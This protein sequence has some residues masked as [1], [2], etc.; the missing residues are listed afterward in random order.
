GGGLS[1]AQQRFWFLQQ[2][3]SESAVYNEPMAFKLIGTLDTAALKQAI[4]EIVRRHEVLRG[5]Y[6][7]V[8]GQVIQ[9]VS[10]ILHESFTI[11]QIDLRDV[12]AAEREAALQ[13][14]MTQQAQ[15]P[16]DLER[17]VPWRIILLKLDDEEHVVLA[18][19]HHII[20]DAWSMEVFARELATLY[21]A[22][23]AQ[24]PSPLPELPL[25]YTD[26][27]RWQ[28][29]RL[30]EGELAGELA[31]WKR[32]LGGTLPVLELPSDRPRSALLTHRGQK[33][34]LLLPSSLG[35][36]LRILSRQEEVTLFMTLLAVFKVLLFRYTGQ[37][38]ILVGSP[39]ANRGYPA[40]ENLL[41]CFVNTL[42]LRTDMAGNPTFR[43]LLQRVRAITMDAYE[44]QD[45]PFEKLV[46][47]LL[48]TRDLSHSALFQVLF[49]MQNVPLAQQELPG[50][51]ISPIDVECGT[52]KFDVLLR[53]Q[54]T[55][56]ALHGYLE[57][58]TDLF[59]ASTIERMMGH[60]RQLLEAV[61]TDP[62]QHIAALPFLTEAQQQQMAAWNATQR[63]YPQHC[64]L[65]ELVEA[66]VERTPAAI[67]VC[68]EQEQLTY[69][70]LNERANALARYL[71]TLGVGPEILVGVCMERSIEL[72]VSLLAI[73]KAGGA[74]VPLDPSYP[75][76]RLAFL[77]QDAQ[78]ALLLIQE[79]LH[80][81]LPRHITQVVAVDSE[82]ARIGQESTSNPVNRV[83]PEHLAY[84]IYTSGSTG[85]PKG[86]MNS[87]RAICNRLLWMQDAYQLQATDRVLQKTPFSFDVSVWEFF[88]PLLTGARL[89]VAR[90]NG[91]R[92]GAYLVQL[93]REAQ[94]TVL[95]F[96]PSMLR[97]FLEEPEVATC[98]GLRLVICSGE[99]LAYEVQQRF[100]EH[101]PGAELHNLYG[102]TEAAVDVTSWA[103]EPESQRR[104]V[105]IGSPIAN[106]RIYVLDTHLNAMPIGI[107]G[108]LHIGGVGV[109]RGY[110]NRPELTAEKFIPDPFSEEP[111]ARLYKTGDL[112]RYLPGGILE[113]V[114]RNDHQVKLRGFRIELGEIEAELAGYPGVR[115]CAVLV[116]EDVPDDKRLVAY[117][118][119]QQNWPLS[120]EE[121]QRFIKGVLPDYMVPSAFMFLE[122]LPLSANGKLDRRALPVPGSARSIQEVPFEAPHDLIEEMVAD[123]WSDILGVELIGIHNDFFALGGHSLL[124]TQV[125]SRIRN[126]FEVELQLLTLF[127]S[128]TVAGLVRHIKAFQQSE[129]GLA[130]PPMVPASRAGILPL[131]FT[132]QRLWF[133]D[134]LEPANPVYNISGAVRLSGPLQSQVVER[135]IN[136]VVR[137]HEIL[138]TT[139][140]MVD[141]Q[142]LQVI[143][144]SLTLPL[145]TVD[146]QGLHETKRDVEVLRLISEEMR[147]PFDLARGP[148][149]RSTL[150]KLTA[151]EHILMLSVHHIVSDGWSTSVFVRELTALY[152][153]FVKDEMPSPLPELPV[154]YVDYAL[155]QQKWLQGEVLETQLAFWKQ[156]LAGLPVLQLPTDKPR[157]AVQTFHGANQQIVLTEPLTRALKALSR[158]EGVTLFMTLLATY[159]T[160][161]F[162]YTDQND[163]AVGIPIAGRTE[164]SLEALIG[165]FIN[166]LALRSDLSG[167]PTFRELLKRVRSVA[168]GA[169]AHQD[170]PFEKLVEELQ[171]D[172]DL[173]RSPLFQVM[174]ALQNVPREQVDL[175]E[176]TLTHLRV[177]SEPALFDLDMTLWESDDE[178]VGVLNYNTDLFSASTIQR[179]R[180]N[181]QRLLETVVEDPGQHLLDLPLLTEA[182]QE[183]IVVE[184]NATSVAYARE[185]TFVTLF[186][187][188][189]ERTP[190]AVA[191]RYARAHITYRQLNQRA[192]QVA[193]HLHDCSIGPE[194]LVALLAERD[195]PFLTAILAVFKAGGAYLPL[196]PQHP[197]ARLRHVLQHSGCH[198][199]LTA[200][201]FASALSE[202]LEEIPAETRPQV[203]LLEELLQQPHIQHNLAPQPSPRQLAY[204][205]YTSG[206]TGRPKGAMVEQ[207][208]MLNHLYAKIADLQLTEADRVAQT[209]S[210]CFDISVWQ[211][212]AALVVGG[213]VQIFP[214]EVTPDPGRL[215]AQVEE[216]HISILEIVPSMMRAM[217][218]VLELSLTKELKLAALRWLIPTGEALPS[219]LCRH[220]LRLY[221]AIPL[222][223]AYGPTECSDDVTHHPISQLLDETSCMMP[224]GRAIGN[225]RLYVLDRGMRP[226][227]IGVSG[228]LYIG[229]IGVG[230]GYV[231]DATRTAEA[232]VPDPF[233]REFG[234][235]L[236]NTGDVVRYLN[237]CTLEFLGRRDHQVKIRGYRI[238][239]GEIEAV[240]A[241]H[242]EVRQCAVLARE[243]VPG[244]SRLVAY[245][246]P[247]QEHLLGI[248]LKSSLK[249]LLP[250]YMVPSAFVFIKTLPLTPNGKLNRHALPAPD[251]TSTESGMPFVAPRNSVEEVLTGIWA[252]LLG[253]AREHISIHEDF[254]AIGGH[255]LLTVRLVSEIEKHFEVRLPLIAIFQGRTVEALAEVLRLQTASSVVELQEPALDLQAE[256]VL[257]LDI[258]P[259]VRS[260]ELITRP[261][262]LLLTG[263]TGFLG[264]FLLGELLQHTAAQI[265]CLLRASS[266]E[267]AQQRLQHTLEDA[268]LWQPA[269]RCRIVA[270]KGDLAEPLLGLSQEQFE[271]LAETLEVIYHNGA[272]VNTLYPY[273]E[274]KA[275]NV[276][277][278]QEILRLA[279]H[280]K[281]KPLHYIS[282]LSVFS[283]TATLQELPILED[284]GSDLPDDQR[285]NSTGQRAWLD[286]R[287]TVGTDAGGLRK[288]SDCGACTT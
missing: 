90:P 71:Q 54:E 246:V 178:I 173:S 227:P 87:H 89:V 92:D 107:P 110:Y 126:T 76:E 236:Y 84:L 140:A 267:E 264:C 165:C 192:N 217:L 37:E 46:E 48:P 25:Q 172:R 56:D 207:Q 1:F 23:S 83:K 105:P 67:A 250:D 232:F 278:T 116:R 141:G 191:A 4:Q 193:H 15:Y 229:G 78:V 223:N 7:M 184:W 43:Q 256:A 44:H 95:H 114:G 213:Q 77:L 119:A 100:F 198:L 147:L 241:Q 118:V 101:L 130:M 269:Y 175:P 91:H 177:D 266:T 155:W 34:E 120:Q 33:R 180:N 109:G 234:A 222:L 127:E 245:V 60:F 261:S 133:F 122:E 136:E 226:V 28:R 272:L 231:A 199:V 284:G 156:Q 74:Y 98:N 97:S 196:D 69:R 263:A 271:E 153:A 53:L 166:T 237:D 240:L 253:R 224:I 32:Q 215:L 117:V 262:H 251:A 111:G 149:L 254:F 125:I 66:Q 260:G 9:I 58:N 181:F 220:W 104:I 36:A 145:T 129:H 274:L 228:E 187:A 194:R 270:V 80:T 286:C 24:Q 137:R 85:K 283:H 55:A 40:Y 211:F 11:K 210:Q 65:H 169:Y 14:N 182:E 152:A 204:V 209:A 79:R 82:W 29:Q 244:D 171:S 146:L 2:L 203:L 38:D 159:Q 113:Y 190:D 249:E 276:L 138:R 8:N 252:A 144:P 212:L 75:Q 88:W 135:C 183:Q 195:I 279:T 31:Y 94:I 259:E 221:P 201:V 39:T 160:L 265:Y 131:S 148:L 10:P 188:Q 51:T 63:A 12:P 277:G 248:E 35:R 186:E 258:C 68:F 225:I 164:S 197:T 26:Y 62:D 128:P 243:D 174:F 189:V 161:L 103:C 287:G 176:L 124:A 52:A 150:L 158:R 200:S 285:I 179:I 49:V 108:E 238:E 202:A 21:A 50:F 16:F 163:F 281:V 17:E 30:E 218:E 139:F 64:T 185:Q 72:V 115:E 3:E 216:Q 96:V 57:Y 18:V 275:P 239:L 59:E 219:D 214:D 268:G 27:A 41:G 151:E 208:G 142:P 5:T 121:L 6:T 247:R 170:L 123:I 47:E 13:C 45:V 81:C 154:Q 134:L 257:G 273:Q 86:A 288:S 168:L 93:L 255:S 22:F 235:R 73:L 19:M 132:Q 282:T 70:Q 233:S 280:G 242:P 157:P 106:I 20:T 162:R 167:N 205:I 102:P 61:V 230:R 206:S 143:A 42:V 99:A 112:V